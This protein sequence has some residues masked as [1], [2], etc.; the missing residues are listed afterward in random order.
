LL[1]AA[2][3]TATIFSPITPRRFASV[4]KELGSDPFL[5]HGDVTADRRVLD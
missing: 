5:E 2:P 1:W 3:S 4:S